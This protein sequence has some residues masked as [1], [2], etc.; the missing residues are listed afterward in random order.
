MPTQTNEKADE[1]DTARSS[2]LDGSVDEKRE[3]ETNNT[4]QGEEEEE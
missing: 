1:E 2:K 3:E 4:H